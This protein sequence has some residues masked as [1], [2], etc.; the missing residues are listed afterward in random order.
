[1]SDAA[2]IPRVSAER[3]AHPTAFRLVGLAAL[4]FSALYVLSDV[5]EALQ[6][7]FSTGQ[8]WLTLIA[9]ASIPVFVIAL[10]ATQRPQIGT[11]GRVSALAYAYSYVFFTGTVV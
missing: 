1:M 2:A 9:E 5:V 6:G 3:R 8:L 11:L 4:V 7:G 10:F